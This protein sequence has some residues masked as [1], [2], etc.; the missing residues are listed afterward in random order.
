MTAIHD[1]YHERFSAGANGTAHLLRSRE[2]TRSF[3]KN[4]ITTEVLRGV[5][6]SLNPGE[7]ALITGKSGAGKSVLLWLLALLDSPTSGSISLDGT[8]LDGMSGNRL[9]AVRR[10]NVRIIFQDFNLIGSWTALENVTASFAGT[11]IPRGE[12][13]EKARRILS[14]LGLSDRLDHLP[15]EL[16][17]GQRQRV[18]IAR[19]IVVPPRL[20]LADE[21]TGGLDPETGNEIIELLVGYARRRGAGL[22]VATHGV[23]PRKA[24]DRVYELKDGILFEA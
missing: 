16:S 24:A 21:P 18:A 5:S 10:K 7:T 4:G 2:I 20:I 17:I 11:R 1:T 13:H 15:A 12:Q 9:T 6:F 14:D 22:V 19:S 3:Q 23:F 8:D